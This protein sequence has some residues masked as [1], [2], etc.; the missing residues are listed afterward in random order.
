LEKSAAVCGAW[1]VV[2]KIGPDKLSMVWILALG[3][4]DK[5][6]LHDRDMTRR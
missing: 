2:D 6:L 1:S 5:D 4:I 3:A